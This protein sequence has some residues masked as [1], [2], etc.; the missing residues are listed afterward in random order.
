MGWHGS[1][2]TAG[3]ALGAPAAGFAVDHAGWSAGF[4]SVAVLGLLAAVVGALAMS[5]RMRGRRAPAATESRPAPAAV[6]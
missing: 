4:L 1:F 6:R 5:G 3:M 2:M